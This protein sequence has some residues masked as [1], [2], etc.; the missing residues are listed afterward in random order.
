M[1]KEVYLI[2]KTHLD[3]G[4]TDLAQ[5]VVKNYLDNFIPNAIKRGY[6]L[7]GTDTPY[8]WSVGS[9][10]LNEALKAD[11]DGTVECAIRDNLIA[12][13][14]MPYTSFTESMS[15]ELMDY[16][17]SISANLDARFG[18]T[19]IAAKMSDVPGHTKA[20]I[21]PFCKHGIKFL[22]LG[23]N[24]AYP[25][26][27]VPP[28]FRWRNGNDEI[29]VMYQVGYGKEM[30]FDDFAIAF[31]FTIDNTGPQSVEEI[32]AIYAD[33]HARYPDAVIYPA[34]LNDAAKALESIRETL[35]IVTAEIGDKWIQNVGTDPKKVSI[36][37]ELLRHIEK[38][39]IQ[40]D[41][42][43]S[44]LVIPEHTWGADM[45]TFFPNYV[46]YS[47]EELAKLKDNP[48]RKLFEQSWQEKRDCL[49]KAQKALGTN[50]R[51]EVIRPDLED[52]QQT[53]LTDMPFEVSWQ[54]FDR[55]DYMR[56]LRT[57][58]IPGQDD[59][60]WARTWVIMDNIKFALP[61]Y[62]G[63]IYPAHP[64]EAYKKDGETVIRLLFDEQ[65]AKEQGLPELFAILI[66]GMIEIRW[67]NQKEN[68][69][70]QAYW[71]KL[72]GFEEDWEIRKIGQWLSTEAIGNP[73]LMAS[74]YGVRNKEYEIEAV[75]SLLVA[76]CGRRM[77]DYEKGPHQQDLY[78]N[79]YNNTW[80]CNHPMWYGED[81]R[82][83]FKIHP[84]GKTNK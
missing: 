9:W 15:A 32:Q 21:K 44:L 26:P 19:T 2:F 22:H 63:A 16:A 84:R 7:R 4:F 53:P 59:E 54:L 17:L 45:K 14:G 67:F 6:E 69:L 52:F 24:E 35:P 33:L 64:V 55:N 68:R 18:K 3:I 60:W 61:K 78:F 39:G 37:K 81:S 36:Y 49:D 34:T 70:P 82:F 41:I 77:L 20:L 28:V 11:K 80:G 12:W 76:P 42:S 38:N 5:N 30:A 29:I 40:A 57:C 23:I 13:H 72:K 58:L 65:I 51:Y 48:H 75:D 66:D 71:I 10:I 1:I 79:L 31:G 50:Y 62:T 43:D 83:R 27:D 56:F 8:V 46:D 73:F 47:V 25:L 74:D